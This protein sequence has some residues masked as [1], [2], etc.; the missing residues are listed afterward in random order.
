MAN[1]QDLLGLALQQQQQQLLSMPKVKH[2][3]LMIR[4]DNFSEILGPARNFGPPPCLGT[5]WNRYACDISSTMHNTRKS[6]SVDLMS[7]SCFLGWAVVEW[8]QSSDT[9]KSHDAYSTGALPSDALWTLWTRFVLMSIRGRNCWPLSIIAVCFAILN[10]WSGKVQPEI[11]NL[12]KSSI[13]FSRMIMKI[14]TLTPFI[15]RVRQLANFV[16]L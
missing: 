9:N 4:T 11:C 2:C 10:P 8:N 15:N 12:C 16:R 13:I 5:G 3:F 6:D 1:R 14:A 7:L